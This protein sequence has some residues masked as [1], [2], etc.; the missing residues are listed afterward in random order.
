[1]NELVNKDA[2]NHR[3][4]GGILCL[5]FTNTLNGHR[6]VVMHEYLLDYRDLVLWSRHAGI[7]NQAEASALLDAAARSPAQAAP[8]LEKATQLR[9][10]FFQVFSSLAGGAAPAS[11]DLERLDAAR[12]EAMRHTRL[13]PIDAGFAISWDEPSALERPLWQVS[14]SAAELL[15]SPDVGRISECDGAGCDW[16][17]LDTSRNHLRRWCSMEE[18]GNRAKMRR[19]YARQR[20]ADGG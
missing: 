10:T 11:E 12:H 18:C 20:E 16:L 7:L 1:M 19:R 15:V 4:V 9:Q 14:L 17:F 5:D 13:V 2:E 3:L 8:V 6:G